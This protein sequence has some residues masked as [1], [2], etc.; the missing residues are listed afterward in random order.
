MWLDFC[1]AFCSIACCGVF[2]TVVLCFLCCT[3]FLFACVVYVFC[4]FAFSRVL[5]FSVCFH[6]VFVV[7][8]DVRV[9]CCRGLVIC[10]LKVCVVACFVGGVVFCVL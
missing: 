2:V 9:L 7:L 1:F 3:C 8:F 4:V 5:Y 10:A 6:C